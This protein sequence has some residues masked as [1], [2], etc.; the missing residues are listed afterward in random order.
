LFKVLKYNII[1]KN[2]KLESCDGKATTC[3]IQI[4]QNPFYLAD[5]MIGSNLQ[6]CIEIKSIQNQKADELL[7]KR[8]IIL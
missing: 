2:F 7:A 3:D 4:E 5:E 6:E 1:K 8:G